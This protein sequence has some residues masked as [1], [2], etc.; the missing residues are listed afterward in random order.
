MKA[1]R[2]NAQRQGAA[3]LI[4]LFIIMAIAVLSLGFLSRSDV[5]LACGQNMILR[6]QMDYLAESGLEHAKG[7]TLHPQDIAAEYWTGAAGQQL[8]AGSSDFYD[9]SVTRDDSDPSDRCNYIIDCNSYRIRAGQEMGRSR[10]SAELR[11]DPCIALWTGNNTTIWSGVTIN[12]DVYCGGTLANKGVIEGD[13]FAGDLSGTVSG[14]HKAVADLSLVWP[15][16]TVADFTSHYATQTIS[17][18]SLSNQVLGPYNPVRVCYRSGHLV[19]AGNVQIEGMLLVEGDL[20]IQGNDN[21][22]TAAKNLPA[23]LV[24]GNLIV[25]AG[26]RLNANGLAVVDGKMQVSASALGV[27]ILGGLFVQDVITEMTADSS[28]NGNSG[29]LF[30]GPTWQPLGGQMGGGIEFGDPGAGVQIGTIG[31]DPQQGSLSLW[32]YANHFDN[33][34]HFMFAHSSIP[35]QG[36]DLVQFYTDDE[37]GWLDLGLGDVHARHSN[38]QKLATH[39]WYHIVLTWN[40]TN[41]TVYVDGAPRAGGAY[42]GLSAL[43]A[44]ADIGNDGYLRDRSFGGIVDDVRIY[45]RV[46]DPNEVVDVGAGL[47]VAGTV[48]HWGLDDVGSSVQITAAPCKTAIILW[49]EQGTEQKWQQAAGAF[50]RSVRR[51]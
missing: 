20:T 50:F 4:V 32:I 29:V 33:S 42:T 11:L 14:R 36:M 18:G 51:R 10:L 17:S 46:L 44:T 7:L 15:R 48:G 47:I 24:T 19:L 12:G 35:A 41:Y 27:T 45:S 37:N 3:L 21:I 9:V 25:E 38:I 39:R 49:S 1:R 16:V 30:G 26:G 13:V 40:G 5:E 31:L 6:T 8:V 22:I 34:E 28:G 23:L 43:G 2:N